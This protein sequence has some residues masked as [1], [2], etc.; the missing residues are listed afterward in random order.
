M[1]VGS[2]IIALCQLIRIVLK[3]IDRATK[4][5]Q[6]A[7][8]LLKLAMKCGQ[9]AMWCLQKT[10]EFISFYGYIFVAIDGSSFCKA[11]KDTFVLVATFPA[12]VAVNATVKKL[13]GL[14]M[15]WST[16]AICATLCFYL[17]DAN[18]A[19]KADGYSALYASVFV[20]IVALVI[21]T[22][23]T[24][25]FEC[26]LDT[27]FLCCFKDMKENEPPKFMSDDL[28]DGFGIDKAEEEAP[29]GAAKLYAPVKKEDKG[30]A[31]VGVEP[32]PD[33]Y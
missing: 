5:E 30:S 15:S 16:P 10:V 4:Q 21:S 20:F 9:C 1:A 24:T 25:V 26:C 2:F 3:L 7:N 17:L 22:S 29:Q 32:A 11:C 13:L 14:L 28:R 18:E 6:N 19:Y 12:Q 23:T 8:L 33:A 31:K 27:I